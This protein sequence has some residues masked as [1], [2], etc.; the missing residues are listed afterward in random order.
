MS[1][2][3]RTAYAATNSFSIIS[4]VTVDCKCKLYMISYI[5]IAHKFRI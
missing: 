5:Y 3:I 2:L 1:V 4:D